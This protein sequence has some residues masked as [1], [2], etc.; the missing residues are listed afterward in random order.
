MTGSA[1]TAARRVRELREQIELHNYQYYALDAPLVSDAEYDRLFRELQALEAAHPELADPDSP[2]QRVGAVPQAQFA[3]VKHGSP[4][5]SLNNAFDKDDVASFDRRAQDALGSEEIEYAAEPKFDGLAVTLVYENGRLTQGATRG[6]GYT[7]EDVTA[8]LRTIGAIPLALKGKGV[9]PVLDVRG[10]VLM[11]K[12]DFAKLN[13]AQREK[14]EKIFANP[15]NAAAGSLRQLDPAITAT[16][17]LTF[18]AYGIGGSATEAGFVKHSDVLDFLAAQRFPVARERATVRGLDGML[19]YYSKV[20]GQRARLPYDID[21]V[22]YKVNDLAAQQTLGF[23]SRAPRFALAHKFPAEEAVSDVLAIDVQVGRTGALTPVA[24]LRPVTVGGVS[25]TNATLHNEDE[26]RRKDIHV[27]DFV[28]VRRAGDVIPEVVRVVE[29]K[30]PA[31][32]HAFSMPTHCPV[33]GSVVRRLEDEAVARCT[34][35][36]FCPA[37]RKQAL[38]HFA[39]RRAMDIEGLG[40]KLVEQLVDMA[41]VETPADL[42]KLDVTMLSGLERM[43]E[44][45][46]G[47]VIAAIEKSKHTTLARLIFALGIR[48][49]GESTARDLARHFGSIHALLDADVNA[50]ERVPDVGPV[51]A[52]SIAQFS[53]EP[54]N[55]AVIAAL[56]AAG[57]KPEAEARVAES[58]LEGKTFVLTG[59]LP[60][61]H[62]DEAK[63]R[64]E[65]RGGRVAGSVSKKTDYVVAGEE[66]GSK[67]EKARTLGITVLD[68]DG[69]LKLLEE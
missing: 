48:N 24:R 33:C 49:V 68:E 54:H 64:I 52:Q 23:V 57:V 63:R 41:M 15:R 4:M 44:K 59:T 67:L 36:L 35:G 58:G 46:A 13:A 16:R 6:D 11:L 26:I 62:R 34:A 29:E 18:F 51:V 40:E 43:A 1:A 17:R 19:D 10:E 69:L 42:Y 55:R 60:G 50:L 32:V 20:G 9:P 22:V 31:K 14:G 2:T 56:L 25:V 8:N 30:R 37:Q 53:A 27:G 66:P 65:A 3:P 21:G 5:L 28:V 45:S 12:N 61:M 47:N 39:S 7:G 38:L